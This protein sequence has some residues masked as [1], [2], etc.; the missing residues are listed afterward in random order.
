MVIG[1]AKDKE[2]VSNNLLYRVCFKSR[3][4]KLEGKGSPVTKRIA[5]AWGE[6]LNSKYPT[7]NPW[8]EKV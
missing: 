3:T 8:I 2:A 6:Y 1:K 5:I 4:S 7:L